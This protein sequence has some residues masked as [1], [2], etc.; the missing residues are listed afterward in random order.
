[1]FVAEAYRLGAELQRK[2]WEKQFDARLIPADISYT[3]L[4]LKTREDAYRAFLETT[5]ADYLAIV[6]PRPSAPQRQPQDRRS[7]Q[8]GAAFA[9]RRAQHGQ[10]R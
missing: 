9:A 2:E 8:P 10:N 3:R 7:G 1:M 6:D 5:L 4:E